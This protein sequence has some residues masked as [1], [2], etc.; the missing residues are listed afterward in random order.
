MGRQVQKRKGVKKCLS[1]VRN[2]GVTVAILSANWS[3]TFIEG[4]VE[5]LCDSVVTNRLLFD[6]D[7]YSTGEI[8]LRVVSAHDKW[9]H[10]RAH[11]S[12]IGKTAYVGDSISDLRAIIEADV[13]I[14]VGENQ[15][16]LRTINRFQ[17]P[18]QRITDSS[19]ANTVLQRAAAEI[20]PILHADSWETVNDLLKQS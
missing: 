11:Q 14:L 10:F 17:I 8:Q 15:T 13:G 2:A 9:R 5:G 1:A 20:E 6:E 12:K 7:G 18:M 19:N 4:A 3:E 16:C